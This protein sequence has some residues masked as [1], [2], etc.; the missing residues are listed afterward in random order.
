MK[1]ALQYGWK[2]GMEIPVFPDKVAETKRLI[3]YVAKEKIITFLNLNE[4]EISELTI[5][6]F[7]QRGYRIIGKETYA[8][9]GSREAARELM[10]Y[11]QQYDMP[12]HFCTTKLKDRVQMG[13]RIIRRAEN[14]AQPFD[15]VDEEG[16]LTRGAIYLDYPP[17]FGYA[18][19]LKAVT[20]DDRAEEVVRLREILIW[21]R[22]RG[23]PEDGGAIDEFRLR[24]VLG[25][26]AL[27]AISS[28]LTKR[29]PRAT[30]A[31]ITEYPTSDAFIVEMERLQKARKRIVT[32][33]MKT[34]KKNI[35]V[36]T[37]Q[38]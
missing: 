14:E 30:A 15:I 24:V 35:Q 32:K 26:D 2:I 9:K 28:S 12:A 3:D 8:I 38:N 19:R 23:M 33:R 29:F 34:L 17:E 16:L 18:K 5:D 11:A 36:R 27:R 7:E 31:A 4:L 1:I 37:K 20:I 22:E 10:R 13:N 25:A 6:T 21:L